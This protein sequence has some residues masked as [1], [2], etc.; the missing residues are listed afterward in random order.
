M[1][2]CLPASQQ[3]RIFVLCARLHCCVLLFSAE[4]GLAWN[5]WIYFC[6]LSSLDRCLLLPSSSSCRLIVAYKIFITNLYRSQAPMLSCVC[7]LTL[8]FSRNWIGTRRERDFACFKLWN[9]SNIPKSTAVWIVNF[10]PSLL[11]R[12]IDSDYLSTVDIS[13][14]EAER[15]ECSTCVR[16]HLCVRERKESATG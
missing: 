1:T 3:K 10:S 14:A 7:E 6:T 15:R 12:Y 13:R 9:N 11:L 2:V 4:V 8:E 16:H 5:C